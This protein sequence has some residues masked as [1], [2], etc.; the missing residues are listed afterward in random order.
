[1]LRDASAMAPAYP[2][3]CAASV[4]EILRSLPWFRR[5]HLLS[6]CGCFAV[7]L[8]ENEEESIAVDDVLRSM[9]RVVGTVG[10]FDR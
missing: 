8:L 3:V 5:S 10:M 1:M 7:K 2:V 4:H 6:V 9:S